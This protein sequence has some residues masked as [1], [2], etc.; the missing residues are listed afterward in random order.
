MLALSNIRQIP[1]ELEVNE[2]LQFRKI[3]I[4]KNMVDHQLVEEFLMHNP[5]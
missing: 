3:P 4:K 1:Q 5:I 2:T